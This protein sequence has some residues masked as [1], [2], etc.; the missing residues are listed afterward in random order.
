V[1]QSTTKPDRERNLSSSPDVIQP[2][3]QHGSLP[4]PRAVRNNSKAGHGRRRAIFAESPPRSAIL[5]RL[6]H[7]RSSARGVK[8]PSGPGNGGLFPDAPQKLVHSTIRRVLPELSFF[9][10]VIQDNRTVPAFSYDLSM[11]LIERAIGHSGHIE[12]LTILPLA[13]DSWLITGF[14]NERRSTFRL[15]IDRKATRSSGVPASSSPYSLRKKAVNTTHFRSAHDEQSSDED[16]SSDG[17]SFISEDEYSSEDDRPSVKGKKNQ[18]K[19][20]EEAR[21][22]KCM[23]DKW[24]WSDIFAQF[25]HRTPGAVRLRGHMLRQKAEKSSR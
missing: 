4:L 16:S 7:G 2:T 12:A 19:A 11:A 22:E 23:R 9:T 21:L 5:S 24:K 8:L 3:E 13:L 15:G 10:T 20:S 14:L 18:W 25:P 6:P 17:A 1:E